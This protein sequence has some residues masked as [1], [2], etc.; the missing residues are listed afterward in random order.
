MSR[1]EQMKT[2][3]EVALGNIPPD[4]VFVRGTLFNA[5]TGE[6]VPGQSIWIKD[7]M[8]AYV[9]PDSNPLQGDKTVVIDAGGQTLLPGLIDGHTH[10]ISARAGVEEFIK[11]VI[12]SGVTTVVTETIEFATVVGKA[13]IEYLAK[14]FEG[15]PIRLYHTVSPLCGLTPSEEVNVPSNEE[16]LSLLRDPKCVGLGEVYWGNIFLTGAQGERVRELAAAALDLGKRVEG[17]GAGASGKKLQAYSCF[18]VSSDHEPI[19]ENEVLERLGLGYWVMVREGAVRK[20]LTGVR[21][22]F[23]KKIHFRRLV[24]VTDG[25]DPEGFMEEGYLDASLKSA[26]KLGVPPAVVYQ[27]VTLNPAEHFRLDHLIGSLSPGKMADLVIIPS[28]EIFKPQLVM[29]G[30]KIIFEKGRSVAEP[31]KVTFPE[32][33]YQT[34]KVGD[35]K[36]PSLPMKGKARAMELVTRLVTKE[37]II[38]LEDPEATKD[39]LMIIS[40]DRLG[41]GKAFT[42]FIKGFGLRRGAYGTTMDWDCVDMI[43]LGQD[44]RSIETVIG[45]LEEIGGGGVYAIDNEVVAEFHAP[46]CGIVSRKPLEIVREEV[47]HL[48]DA[49]KRNGVRWEKP[50][51]TVDTLGTPAIPHLRITHQGYVRLKDWKILP[52]EV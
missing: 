4:V 31:R 47:R 32:D 50:V 2:L 12:P 14:G 17:H 13:G 10:V 9:G 40:I 21:G 26:I 43:V 30:G 49:L 7:G 11:Y 42:G 46:L 33:M 39:L 3:S 1:K 5:F 15:Q 20:E 52:V 8:I 48:E 41:R 35:F 25:M 37:S 44:P 28:P 27:M 45:R 34:V 36:L 23:E 16:F 29:C 22:I 6:F 38:D 19:M 18:G 24:L 51:L